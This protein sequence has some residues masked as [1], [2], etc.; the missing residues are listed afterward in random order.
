MA[1]AVLILAGAFAVL[2][3]WV[4]QK[5]WLLEAGLVCFCGGDVWFLLQSASTAGYV[6]G[7]TVDITWLV[8]VGLMAAATWAP[9]GEE[10]DR[11]PGTGT[12]LAVPVRFALASVIL[13]LVASLS[14]LVTNEVVPWLAGATILF[15]LAR[16]TLTFREVRHL[17][18]ARRRAQTNEL[19]GLPNRRDFLEKLS[20][21]AAPTPPELAVPRTRWV[22]RPDG[23]RRVRRPAARGGRDCSFAGRPPHERRAARDLPGVRHGPAH[24]RQHRHRHWHGPTPSALLRQADLAMDEAKRGRLGHAIHIQQQPG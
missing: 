7:T 20:L 12:L 14:N 6:A 5:R 3:W 11:T 23:R 4:G 21:L 8:G 2:G 15:A 19:T 22:P 24:R 10:H 1:D 17:E 13:L 9:D 16:T 18:E